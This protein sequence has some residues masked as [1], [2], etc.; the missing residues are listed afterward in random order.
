MVVIVGIAG[1]SA[2]G[3]KAIC[4]KI[5]Q[6][7]EAN[8]IRASIVGLSG[9]Y[10]TLS[11]DEQLLADRE[12]LDFDNPGIVDFQLLTECLGSIKRGETCKIPLWSFELH[13]RLDSKL[14]SEVDAVIVY[15]P[16]TLYDRRVRDLFDLK[17]FVVSFE[18]EDLESTAIEAGR[19]PGFTS[20]KTGYSGY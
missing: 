19:G 10:R 13:Q 12:E 5:F 11:L 9:F 2:S 18:F 1:G 15:G 6:I 7:L 3:K 17:V 16:L 8:R 20:R 14:I 4:D